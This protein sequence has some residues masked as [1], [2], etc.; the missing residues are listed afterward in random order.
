M[1]ATIGKLA[2]MPQTDRMPVL[3]VGHGNPM[4]AI[5]ENPFSL[6]WQQLGRELPTPTAILC[7][8]AHWETPDTRV[9]VSPTPATIHDFGGFPKALFE[10]QYPAPGSP[11]LA[12]E[13]KRSVQQ[14]EVGLDTNWGFDHGAWSII[15]HMYPQANIPVVEMSLSYRLTPLQHYELARELVALRHRGV[16]I[17][18]SGNMV[19]NLRLM[20]WSKPD[21]GFEW[22]MQANNTIKQ[23]IVEGRHAELASYQSLGPEVQLAVPT[24]DHFL[25]LLYALALKQEDEPLSFFNDSP[26]MGS[27]TMTSVRI[28]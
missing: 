17:M 10:V 11:E 13:V 4:N 2:A 20:D 9:T 14:A 19:H 18:G 3:F 28:G 12:Y 8:S 7:V 26:V 23:L 1:N 22:A 21:L 6:T 16:L 24:P 5:E 25:P 15:R 27:L